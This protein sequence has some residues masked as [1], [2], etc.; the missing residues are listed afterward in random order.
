MQL[1]FIAEACP[2]GADLQ[3]QRIIH[4]VLSL[5]PDHDKRVM[6]LVLRGDSPADIAAAESEELGL[7]RPIGTLNM[8]MRIQRLTNKLRADV[9]EFRTVG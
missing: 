8:M 5:W 3:V 9:E 7:E 1:S 2:R 4:H 6:E